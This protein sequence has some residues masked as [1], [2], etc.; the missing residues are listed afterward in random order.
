MCRLFE[1]ILIRDGKAPLL[2]WHQ[3]R[4]DRSRRMLFG[5][6]KQIRLESLIRENLPSGD[7]LWRCRV[8]YGKDILG[9]RFVPHHP[10]RIKTLSLVE[11]DS[12]EYPHKFADRQQL[13]KLK[14]KASTDEIIIV[15]QGLVTDA[16]IA[17]LVFW[18]GGIAYTPDT[19]LLAGTRR[20]MLLAGGCIRIRRIRMQDIAG[21]DGIS[22]I[23]ALRPLDAAYIIP[24]KNVSDMNKPG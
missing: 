16:S 19:P 21:Y 10:L 22:L 17:N 3:A 23:N 8:D 15:K 7:G 14:G 24:I 2:P 11:D 9:I 6:S 18:K 13:E 20:E 5:L 4:F 1:T 12:M